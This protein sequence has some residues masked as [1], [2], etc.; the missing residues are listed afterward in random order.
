[1]EL[2]K[3]DAGILT[4]FKRYNGKLPYAKKCGFKLLEGLKNSIKE[5]GKEIGS[6]NSNIARSSG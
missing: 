6:V 4:P 1:M 3:K 2:L 5:E